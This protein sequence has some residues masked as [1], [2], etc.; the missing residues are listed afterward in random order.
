ML[1]AEM[2]LNLLL[3]KSEH[4]HLIANY[5]DDT[6]KKNLDEKLSLIKDICAELGL[7][8]TGESKAW[9][10]DEFSTFV[11]RFAEQPEG[12]QSLN[13]RMIKTFHLRRERLD[14]PESHGA[15]GAEVRLCSDL[16]SVFERWSGTQ[17]K[18]S[19]ERELEPA[20]DNEEV[21]VAFQKEH[22]AELMAD[23]SFAPIG[24][25]VTEAMRAH[26]SSKKK[27]SKP[28]S[29]IPKSG[30]VDKTLRSVWAAIQAAKDWEASGSKSPPRRKR[31]TGFQTHPLTKNLAS[32]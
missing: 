14:D 30:K 17:V 12:K 10:F 4:G 20:V 9:T 13:E 28:L 2:Y 1:P 7:D 31:A 11:Q 3:E 32:I 8:D 21:R 22:V 27:G 18:S 5:L 23:N 19:G 6:K 25:D 26:V 24:S 16:R 29:C 15:Q